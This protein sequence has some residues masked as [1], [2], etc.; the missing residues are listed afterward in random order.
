MLT[1]SQIIL[2]VFTLLL[3]AVS[4]A[5]F[6]FFVKGKNQDIK[7]SFLLKYF[8]VV[9]FLLFIISEIV[10]FIY[11]SKFIYFSGLSAV[12]LIIVTFTIMLI[13]VIGLLPGDV[14]YSLSLSNILKR[15]RTYIQ[16]SAVIPIEIK[17]EALMPQVKQFVVP[18]PAGKVPEEIKHVDIAKEEKV[19]KQ[20]ETV[21]Q[22]P[23]HK[24]AEHLTR[25]K[26]RTKEI[27]C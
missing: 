15:K 11:Y 1:I 18:K 8:S 26:S 9:L 3:I 24:K 23:I 4:A 25:I 2:L 10:F 6:L 5:I 20:A 17:P 21:P 14:L 19:N 13:P 16:P 7:Y 27:R 22:T 12:I